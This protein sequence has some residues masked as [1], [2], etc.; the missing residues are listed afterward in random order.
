MARAAAA[1]WHASM[2]Q[3]PSHQGKLSVGPPF[4]L[5]HPPYRGPLGRSVPLPNINDSEAI[6]EAAEEPD[7]ELEAEV[8]MDVQSL[9]SS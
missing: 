6:Q 7:I 2:G 4:K 8:T 1:E 3:N 5:G 9:A